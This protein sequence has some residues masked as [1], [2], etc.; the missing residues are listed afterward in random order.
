MSAALR[1][2]SG[3]PDVRTTETTDEMG[4]VDRVRA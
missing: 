2:P 3:K 4:F 1:Q